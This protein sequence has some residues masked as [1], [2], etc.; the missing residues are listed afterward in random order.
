MPQPQWET[1]WPQYSAQMHYPL[2][3]GQP[4]PGSVVARSEPPPV[5]TVRH[6]PQQPVVQPPKPPDAELPT[7]PVQAQV[8]GNLNGSASQEKQKPYTIAN[9]NGAQLPDEF[10][11][12]KVGKSSASDELGSNPL[13][14]ALGILSVYHAVCE[15]VPR[16]TD[17]EW[18]PTAARCP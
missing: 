2:V 16:R 8:N 10:N 4:P 13:L 14:L 15:Y 5:E 6:E 11:F 7:Q 1:P 18:Y 3:S 9:T 17:T 12:L